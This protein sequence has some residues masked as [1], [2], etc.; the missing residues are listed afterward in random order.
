MSELAYMLLEILKGEPQGRGELCDKLHCG[1]REV[2]R[3]VKELR[4]HGYN[5]ASSSDKK[6]YW[7]G[8]EEDRQR[9]INELRSRARRLEQTAAA[10][11][12]G[13]DIGQL[14]VAL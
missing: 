1:E 14:E 7:I 6:G 11:E 2:R 13:V 3:A 5:I 12:K 10:L 8:T 9:T 4:E